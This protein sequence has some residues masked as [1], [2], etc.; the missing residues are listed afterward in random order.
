MD[1]VYFVGDSEFFSHECSPVSK[2]TPEKAMPKG[3][4][5]PSGLSK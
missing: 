2:K 4:G 3:N 5:F 1:V